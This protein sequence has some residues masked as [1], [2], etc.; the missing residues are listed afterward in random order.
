M[1]Q[2]LGGAGISGNFDCENFKKK[3]SILCPYFLEF[4][5]LFILSKD[6]KLSLSLH[7]FFSAYLSLFSGLCSIYLLPFPLIINQEGFFFLRRQDHNPY[8]TC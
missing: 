5:F 8:Q 2:E 6:K 1:V 7:Y 3:W 4:F